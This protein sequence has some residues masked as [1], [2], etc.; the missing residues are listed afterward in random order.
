MARIEQRAGSA[1][2]D[3]G[4]SLE[5]LHIEAERLQLANEHVERFGKARI[6]RH[7]ALDDRFVDLRA[8]F[9]VVGLDGQKLLERVGRAVRLESPD[10]HLSET[11]AAELGLAAQGLLRD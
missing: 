6:R 11:L 7:L 4:S 10:L 5:Q 1:L 8:S 2:P 9:D 3:L